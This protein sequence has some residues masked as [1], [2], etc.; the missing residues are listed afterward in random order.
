[1]SLQSA[2]F[3]R[4][5]RNLCPKTTTDAIQWLAIHAQ[6]FRKRIRGIGEL[7]LLRS[8]QWAGRQL[9]DEMDAERMRWTTL[10][11]TSHDR[12]IFLGQEYADR[13]LIPEVQ[14][15]TLHLLAAAKRRGARIVLVSDNIEQFIQPL[16]D[17]VGA[18]ALICNRPQISE[19]GFFKGTL[20]APV[21]SGRMSG[22]WLRAYADANGIDL[23]TSCAYGALEDDSLLLS[24]VG[25]PCAV[26]PDRS[27]RQIAHQLS[28]PVV[29]R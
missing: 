26:S 23:Q 29:E 3:C 22:Q 10:R 17:H 19:Q 21:F 28:W 15:V 7:A 1:M 16:A 4:V 20:E 24:H 2:A 25:Q 18:D 5:E 9:P 8:L 12:L 11:D 14:D 6:S 27:L 13:F